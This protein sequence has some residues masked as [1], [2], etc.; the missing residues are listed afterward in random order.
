MDESSAAELAFGREK[1]KVC[2]GAERT[3]LCM[4]CS[5]A[6]HN[7]SLYF[8]ISR[9]RAQLPSRSLA[10]EEGHTQHTPSSAPALPHFLQH[11]APPTF[12]QPQQQQQE[13]WQGNGAV[14]GVGP[15]PHRQPHFS[16]A[17]G[18][19][20]SRAVR[21][22]LAPLPVNQGEMHCLPPPPTPQ[23][24]HGQAAAAGRA[25]SSSGVPQTA[26]KRAASLARA[27]Q[28]KTS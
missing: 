6:P 16:S 9:K 7:T 14:T 5:P 1:G 28:R 24:Q 12:G 13:A 18:G 22:P 17:H 2:S 10:C 20:R 21:T 4:L 15:A 19:S 11:H 25:K 23:Q 8:H 27:Q 3:L 26:K